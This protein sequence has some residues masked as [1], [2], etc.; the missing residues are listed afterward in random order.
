MYGSKSAEVGHSA[1]YFSREK[2]SQTTVILLT[3]RN[4]CVLSKI[5]L[6]TDFDQNRE[7]DRR[8]ATRPSA[9]A[10]ASRLNEINETFRYFF[11]F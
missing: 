4:A 5:I 9:R 7:I 8:R 1:T 6:S 11:T 10:T 2:K 3:R